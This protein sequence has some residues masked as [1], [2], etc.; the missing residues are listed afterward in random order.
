MIFL[1]VLQKKKGEQRDTEQFYAN[2]L[3]TGTSV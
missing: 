1:S 3:V 2:E